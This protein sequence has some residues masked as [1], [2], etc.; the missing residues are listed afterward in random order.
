MIF[1]CRIE[2]IESYSRWREKVKFCVSVFSFSFYSNLLYPISGVALLLLLAQRRFG[3]SMLL[4]LIPRT[5]LKMSNHEC[6][7]QNSKNWRGN[8]KSNPV[9]AGKKYSDQLI[10]SCWLTKSLT[11][12]IQQK[13]TP[14][15]F[16]TTCTP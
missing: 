6:S 8:D 16:A 3:T 14:S 2:I 13:G 11:S 9:H 12:R 1:P 5:L 7:N 4:S 10:M 15:R